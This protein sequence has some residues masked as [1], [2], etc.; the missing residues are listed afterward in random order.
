MDES[1]DPRTEG[2]TAVELIGRAASEVE[3]VKRWIDN[4]IAAGDDVIVVH[5]DRLAN[6]LADLRTAKLQTQAEA[7]P[8]EAEE[9]QP[10]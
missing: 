6:A 4:E 2:L 10:A 3:E 9:A 1:T 7:S 8:V 5:A